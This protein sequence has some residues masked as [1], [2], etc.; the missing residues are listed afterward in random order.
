[1]SAEIP[2]SA[3]PAK[4]SIESLGVTYLTREGVATE[5]VRDVS[6]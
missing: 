1:M 2:G 5:A 6:L 4:L 3:A